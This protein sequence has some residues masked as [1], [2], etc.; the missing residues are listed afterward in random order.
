[1]TIALGSIERKIDRDGELD[2][3]TNTL[4]IIMMVVGFL[5]C[6]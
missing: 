5:L 3:N 4:Q 2:L 6:S 1:M